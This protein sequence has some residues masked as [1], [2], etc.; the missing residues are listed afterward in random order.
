[1]N[2]TLLVGVFVSAA[3]LTTSS[4][5][6]GGTAAE[7]FLAQAEPVGGGKN[8]VNVILTDFR[9]LDTFGEITVL[10]V[11]ALGISMLVRAPLRRGDGGVKIL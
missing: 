4:V 9:A 7:E 10:L 5:R 6:R 11:A 1:M 8:V 3:L 2:I